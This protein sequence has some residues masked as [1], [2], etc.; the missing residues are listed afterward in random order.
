MIKKINRKLVILLC[1]V[2]VSCHT[3]KKVVYIQDVVDGTTKKVVPYQGIVIQPKDMLSIV[4]SSSKPET[5]AIY[6]LPLV[7]HYAG[8]AQMVSGYQQGLLGYLV[9]TEGNINFPI[10]GK[11]KVSGLT[12]IQLSETIK[13]KLIEE[14]QLK[15]PIVT[16]AFLNFR[17]SILGQV[18]KPGTFN[19]GNDQITLQ[20]ALGLAGDLTIYGSRDN[21][22]VQREEGDKI[23]F[24][25]VDLRSSAFINSPVFYLQQNDVVI[26]QPNK[27]MAARSR[28]NENNRVST[29]IS[30]ASLLTTI[31]VLIVK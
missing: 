19:I 22:T 7:T 12:R 11:M 9:D 10:L 4:V 27:T 1:L 26:V 18:A 2:L 5:A 15:E 3:S 14:D 17:I 28:I 16:V 24:H 20:E 23:V 13:K 29:W 8:N 6:N 21:I 25:Q 30:I 31:T